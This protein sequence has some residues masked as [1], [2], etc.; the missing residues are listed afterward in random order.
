MSQFRKHHL[1]SGSSLR[2]LF[3]FLKS[4]KLFCIQ[5]EFN[6]GLIGSQDRQYCF[7]RMVNSSDGFCFTAYGQVFEIHHLFDGYSYN[8]IH[9]YTH[10]QSHG[11]T[12]CRF[13][14]I[15]WPL[16]PLYSRGFL[17]GIQRYQSSVDYL[18]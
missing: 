4:M 13:T 5:L 15:L 12:I 7:L 8:D 14:I 2:R 17:E 1:H 10:V 9:K 11:G 3:C 6:P 16:S 18:Y